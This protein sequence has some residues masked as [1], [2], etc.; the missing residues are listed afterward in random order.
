MNKHLKLVREFHSAFSYHQ[1]DEGA[2][3][4]PSDMEII[5]RQALLMEA[6]STVLHAL[7]SGDM[8]AILTGLVELAYCALG[9]IAEQ[10]GEVVEYAPSWQH[11]GF[12]LSLMQLVSSHINACTSGSTE[13]YSAVYGLCAHLSRSF[14]N[15]D[16]DKAMQMLHANNMAQLATTGLSLYDNAAAR[17]KL[18]PLTT[19]DLSDCLYE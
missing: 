4:K 3:E 8:V 2:N 12:V 17:K 15:A 6:G 16:F 13:Q 7:K 10:G 19:P 1:A 18:T 14:L 11:D 9:A 5:S